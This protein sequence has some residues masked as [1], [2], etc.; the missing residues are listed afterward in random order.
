MNEKKRQAFLKVMDIQPY[1][2][3]QILVG[4]KP[5]PVYE[6]PESVAVTGEPVEG[7]AAIVAEV[8][9]RPNGKTRIP[10]LDAV[11][12]LRAHASLAR[13]ATVTPIRQGQQ[14]PAIPE[15]SET[16]AD[17]AVQASLSFNLRYYRISDSVAVLDE[18]PSQ[19]TGQ[20]NKES[21]KLMLAILRAL[22]L[23]YSSEALR[24][25]EFSWP[26]Q[27]G[28]STKHSPQVEAAKALSGFLQMRQE[29]D[30]FSNLLVFAGQLEDVLL[31]NEQDLNA[32][33]F[34]SDKGYFITVTHS[35][36]SMLA[37]AGL[38]RDV[39]QHLQPLRKRVAIPK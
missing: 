18:M 17:V 5:S 4:A 20:L 12:E 24:A 19:G 32:R 21:Q 11:E 34:K 35:L 39:W 36:A 38:K 1:F 2:P 15:G 16:T 31:Q 25:E 29:T 23:E 28:Y 37:I 13:K 22:G 30:G 3:R 33:D 7:S 27:A 10:G 9:A 8:E 6:L 26:V 14:P